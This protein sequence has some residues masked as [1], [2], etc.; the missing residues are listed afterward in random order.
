MKK[1][2]VIAAAAIGLA[3]PASASAATP[4]ASLP[5]FYEQTFGQMGLGLEINI[6]ADGTWDAGEDGVFFTGGTWVN[7]GFVGSNKIVLLGDPSCDFL[8]GVY[9]W[10]RSGIYLYLKPTNDPCGE[11]AAA[12]NNPGKFQRLGPAIP[13]LTQTTTAAAT[14]GGAW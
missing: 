4:V 8:P 12:I 6:E 5:G 3:I 7:L 9:Q 11:R 1:F 14:V 2:L 10:R 13:T